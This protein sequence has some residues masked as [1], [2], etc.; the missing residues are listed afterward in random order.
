VEHWADGGETKLSNLIHLCTFHHA[1]VHEGRLRVS[2]DASGALTFFGA[3]GKEIVPAP[4]LPGVDATAVTLEQQNEAQGL[5]ID[6]HSLG[7]WDGIAPDY[8]WGVE[9]LWDRRKGDA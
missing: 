9:V 6:Q 2:V 4:P 8:S 7:L 3:D 5:Q 1:L